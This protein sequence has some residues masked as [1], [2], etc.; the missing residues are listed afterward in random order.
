MASTAHRYLEVVV[1]GVEP[2]DGCALVQTIDGSENQFVVLA[3][4]AGDTWELLRTGLQVWIC[5][6]P[7]RTGK[8]LSVAMLPPWEGDA[9]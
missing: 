8:V 5:V 1:L 4:T 2:E 3:D 6:T 9:S 7:G